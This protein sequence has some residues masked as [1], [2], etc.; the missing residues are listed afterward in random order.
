MS[1]EPIQKVGGWQQLSSDC[2]YENPWIS[3]HH[4]TVKTPSG[5]EGIYGLVHFK[6]HAVGIVPIDAEGYTWLVKQSR[7]T[8]DQFTW[9]IPEGGAA[10]GEDTLACAKRELEEEAGVTAGQ[11]QELMRLHTSNSVTD[12]RAVVYL[13][14][15]TQ[16]GKQHFDASEDIE[17]KRLPL[18]AAIEMALCGEITDAISVAALLKVKVLMGPEMDVQKLC[19]PHEDNA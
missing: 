13:A 6:G 15:D 17:V 9:E 1:D 12:E 18:E 5:A 2:V 3:V 10:S 14:W 16:A 4:Q 19:Q 7:Y 8:L 11:W